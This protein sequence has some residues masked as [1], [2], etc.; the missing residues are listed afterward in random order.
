MCEFSE[1]RTA[2]AAG[3]QAQPR[4]ARGR[5]QTAACLRTV[6]RYSCQVTAFL[7]DLS[8]RYAGKMYQ[9]DPPASPA[10]A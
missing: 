4:S 5:G 1:Q 8:I 9:R 3:A 10:R 2:L 7:R 6:G